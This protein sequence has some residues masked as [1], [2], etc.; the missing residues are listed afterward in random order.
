M[1]LLETE[2]KI[3]PE[4]TKAISVA[5]KVSSELQASVDSSLDDSPPATEEGH[6]A[7][8]DKLPTIVIWLDNIETRFVEAIVIKLFAIL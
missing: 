2:P 5:D 7:V 1:D 6:V 8:D 3:L 4:I